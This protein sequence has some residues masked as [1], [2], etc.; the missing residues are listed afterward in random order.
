MSAKKPSKRRAKGRPPWETRRKVAAA[1]EDKKPTLWERRRPWSMPRGISFGRFLLPAAV[2]YQPV[3]LTFISSSGRR[4][5]T[6]GVHFTP[7]HSLKPSTLSIFYA[8]LVQNLRRVQSF[9]LSGFHG[10]R[11]S[12]IRPRPFHVALPTAIK[13]TWHCRDIDLNDQSSRTVR[14]A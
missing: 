1:A 9:G 3:L 2:F 10:S 4:L 5:K 11:D 6:Q 8:C 7:I 14:K 12:N 13:Y